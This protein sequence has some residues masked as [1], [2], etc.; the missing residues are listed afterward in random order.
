[1]SP[2][3]NTE[4]LLANIEVDDPPSPRAMATYRDNPISIIQD[5]L[6][7]DDDDEQYLRVWTSEN[8]PYFESPP[9]RQSASPPIR[10]YYHVDLSV[11]VEYLLCLESAIT[12]QYLINFLALA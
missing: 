1:M 12:V 10:S 6:T 3:A 4:S 7:Y 9:L 2:S 11:T 8:V 5:D